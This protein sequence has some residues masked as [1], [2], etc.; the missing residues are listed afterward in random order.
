M[1]YLPFRCI[2]L[3]TLTNSGT[4]WEDVTT[5]KQLLGDSLGVWLPQAPFVVDTQVVVL[6][7]LLSRFNRVRLF[8]TP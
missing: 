1:T 8:A 4:V 2:V 3:V 7:L 6:L 5:R